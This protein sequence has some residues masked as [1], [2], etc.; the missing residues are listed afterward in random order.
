MQQILSGIINI[1]L[2][3][4]EKER[5]HGEFSF[6]LSVFFPGDLL[7]ND[8]PRSDTNDFSSYLIG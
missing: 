3:V 5:E 6:S 8:F 2:P 4:P 1:C 7:L